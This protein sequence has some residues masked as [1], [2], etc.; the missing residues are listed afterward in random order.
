[1]DLS[2]GFFGAL[3]QYQGF[4]PLTYLVSSR[5]IYRLFWQK[6]QNFFTLLFWLRY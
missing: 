3:M 2:Q 6:W 1:M 4:E 5:L